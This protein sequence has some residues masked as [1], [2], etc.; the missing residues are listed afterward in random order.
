MRGTTRY[1]QPLR[2][3]AGNFNPRSPCGERR[4]SIKRS[5]P[6]NYFN[7]R[8]PC[9]ERLGWASPINRPMRFQSTLPLRGTTVTGERAKRSPQYFNPRSPC[10]ERRVPFYFLIGLMLFQSTLPLRGT[11]I[12]TVKPTGTAIISIHAPLAGNDH[13]GI[14]HTVSGEYFNPRS[15]CGER[16]AHA[17][18]RPTPCYFNPRSPCGERRLEPFSNCGR[19]VFQSTLPL[20]GTTWQNLRRAPVH[21]DFNP[22]SPCGERLIVAVALERLFAIS[23]HAPLAG[24]DCQVFLDAR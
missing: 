14:Y 22:R 12:A 4:F 6:G 23:I 9:G 19:M 15:P 13:D 10:G 24:N 16:P 1:T 7:P 17:R 2:R 18:W 21:A 3:C 20:R 5:L 11:T 8:S